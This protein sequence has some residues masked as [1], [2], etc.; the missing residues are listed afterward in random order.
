MGDKV[1][2]EVSIAEAAN[3]SLLLEQY[4]QK[5]MAIAINDFLFS[6]TVSGHR[7]LSRAIELG[8]MQFAATKA[9][10]ELALQ[11]IHCAVFRNNLNYLVKNIVRD[12]MSELRRMVREEI[13]HVTMQAGK[14]S[15]PAG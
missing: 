13:A 3:T 4:I 14:N 12:E 2:E 15:N 10:E 11:I 8:N 7:S 9:R 5:K 1:S 6:D